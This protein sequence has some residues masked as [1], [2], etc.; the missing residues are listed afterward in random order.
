MVT[1][2][3]FSEVKTVALFWM[4]YTSFKSILYILSFSIYIK[5]LTI[6]LIIKLKRLLEN[7][8]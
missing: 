3:K 8:P 4:F 6:N 1:D 5:K 2:L 7:T